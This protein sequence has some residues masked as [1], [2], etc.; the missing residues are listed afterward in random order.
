MDRIRADTIE[1]GAIEFGA[2]YEGIGGGASG[3]GNGMLPFRVIEQWD[4]TLTDSSEVPALAENYT[5][6]VDMPTSDQWYNWNIT[7]LVQ[8]GCQG[9][10]QITVWHLRPI[11]PGVQMI[12]QMVIMMQV[13]IHLI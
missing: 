13:L 6:G 8:G 5:T 11:N 10:T 4:E 7:G 3:G 12:G 2:G 9:I 1:G